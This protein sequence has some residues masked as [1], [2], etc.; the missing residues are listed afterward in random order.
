MRRHQTPL[1]VAAQESLARVG[2]HIDEAHD[3][4][5]YVIPSL[6]ISLRMSDDP[7][8]VAFERL[9]A[10]LLEMAATNLPKRGKPIP[11][12]Q[13]GAI[14]VV[15][16]RIELGVTAKRGVEMRQ[17]SFDFFPSCQRSTDSLKKHTRRERLP[18]LGNG[19]ASQGSGMAMD[20]HLM[21]PEAIEARRQMAEAEKKFRDRVCQRREDIAAADRFA[22]SPA[23]HFR[24][25]VQ[26]LV[27]GLVCWLRER[28]TRASHSTP[29]YARS[30]R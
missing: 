19:G 11:E 16:R 26:H 30:G 5:C 13:L 24:L 9:I 25:A 8:E 20:D 27:A 7:R 10:M 28:R 4:M 12:I 17:H 3:T 15:C 18:R 29:G 23:R 6:R 22:Y 21:W 2:N 14:S 1:A